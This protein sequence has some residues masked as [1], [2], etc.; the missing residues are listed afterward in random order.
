MGLGTPDSAEQIS[1]KAAGVAEATSS[2]DR[3]LVGEDDS[4]RQQTPQGKG[5]ADDSAAPT[6][7]LDPLTS[8]VSC[9]D[10]GRYV[11][12]DGT[13]SVYFCAGRGADDGAG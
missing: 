9:H 10:K 5:S 1:E 8:D 7:S 13:G 2:L 12:A 11:P 4:S 3:L 6:P